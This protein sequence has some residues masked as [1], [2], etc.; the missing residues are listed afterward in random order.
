MTR[1][2]NKKR[3]LSLWTPEREQQLR[4]LHADGL[5]AAQIAREMKVF[6][7]EAICSKLHRIDRAQEDA[8]RRP[9]KKLAG[10]TL[11]S[12]ITLVRSVKTGE[13]FTWSNEEGRP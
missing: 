12:P 4:R 3:S 10:S 5:T 1:K 11:N 6:S 7:R 2:Y 13:R 9:R 8:K